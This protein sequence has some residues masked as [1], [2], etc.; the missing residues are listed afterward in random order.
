MIASGTTLRTSTKPAARAAAETAGTSLA[1]LGG[2][3]ATGR[4]GV[5]APVASG[6]DGGGADPSSIAQATAQRTTASPTRRC[7]ILLN[8]FHD[9]AQALFAED[10]LQHRCEVRASAQ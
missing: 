10:G 6:D 1:G 5:A 7:R 3:V 9:A 2:V 4:T 8:L